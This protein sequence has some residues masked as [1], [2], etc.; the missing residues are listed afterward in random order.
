MAA[1]LRDTV[2]TADRS[3]VLATAAWRW[4][5]SRRSSAP[6]A[7]SRTVRRRPPL[8]TTLEFDVVVDPSPADT[9]RGI[10]LPVLN[11]V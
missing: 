1:Q 4:A 8:S 3:T 7:G 9:G 6:F 11:A 2:A 10:P 5:R